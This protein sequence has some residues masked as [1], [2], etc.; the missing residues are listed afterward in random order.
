MIQALR[1]EPQGQRQRFD[2]Q[3]QQNSRQQ[4]RHIHLHMHLYLTFRASQGRGTHPHVISL[5]RIF[6]ALLAATM[7]PLGIFLYA[8]GIA[9][10]GSPPTTLENLL[11]VS[12]CVSVVAGLALAW[13]AVGALLCQAWRASPHGRFG[14]VRSLLL[15]LLIPLAAACY[16]FAPHGAIP[17][18]LNMLFAIP[19]LV[20]LIAH[21]LITALLLERVS[22]ETRALQ[23]IAPTHSKLG[24]VV[25]AGI[26]L[27]LLGGLLMN[28]SF[29]LSGGIALLLFLPAIP[30]AIIV[31]IGTS[32][33]LF[34]LRESMQAQ[35]KDASPF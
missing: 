14:L 23:K 8:V 9:A 17:V 25:V 31:A 10:D 34:R 6:A 22:R 2:P 1:Y 12:S 32:A 19:L 35:P 28:L 7:M 13:C 30:I 4:D 29:M 3:E 21:P 15:P 16:W 24:F 11:W 20:V 5:S 18:F 26:V 27:V 33:R